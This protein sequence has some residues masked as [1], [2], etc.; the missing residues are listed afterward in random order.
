[1]HGEAGDS[2]S[3]PFDHLDTVVD[4]PRCAVPKSR[5]RLLDKRQRAAEIKTTD[6]AGSK[7]ARLRANGCCEI[8]V[9]NEGRCSRRDVHTHHM[10]GGRGVRAR[11]K[12]AL[13]EHKQRVCPRCHE[14]IGGHVLRLLQDGPSPVFTDAYERVR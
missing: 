5:P 12:S 9:V 14:E 3:G 1:L 13:A 4:R 11:G 2:M 10:L 7:Q 6:E 8:F